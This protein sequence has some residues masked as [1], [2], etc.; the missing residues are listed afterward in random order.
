MRIFVIGVVVVI[1]FIGVIGIVALGGEELVVRIVCTFLLILRLSIVVVVIADF[2][3]VS[4]IGNS[5]LLGQGCLLI[6]VRFIY[7]LIWA[8]W[9]APILHCHHDSF[10]KHSHAQVHV[11][12]FF[13]F[14]VFVHLRTCRLGILYAFYPIWSVEEFLRLSFGSVNV[15]GSLN[16]TRNA[17]SSSVSCFDPFLAILRVDCVLAMVNVFVACRGSYQSAC[18]D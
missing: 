9:F 7:A 12:Y 3:R 16:I 14:L 15:A 10:R 1:G 4:W 11:F 17:L 8:L 18:Q 6:R 13:F 5:C 2:N